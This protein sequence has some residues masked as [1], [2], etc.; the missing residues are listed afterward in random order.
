MD[1]FVGIDASSKRVAIA[2]VTSKGKLLGH[3]YFETN[4]SNPM[5]DYAQRFNTIMD[6]LLV[7]CMSYTA[8]LTLR[9]IFVEDAYM[10][11]SRRGSVNHAKVV[12]NVLAACSVYSL[13]T[14]HSTVTTIMPATWRSRCGIKGRGKEPVAIWATERWPEGGLDNQDLI[15]AACIAYAGAQIAA[16]QHIDNLRNKGSI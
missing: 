11:V 14:D 2:H 15:D 6:Y 4:N 5:V 12:G 10:G 3:H 8:K 16:E 1:S 9:G 13:D 7:E